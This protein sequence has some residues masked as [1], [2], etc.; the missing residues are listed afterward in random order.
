MYTRTRRRT[1][2]PIDKC[3]RW[4]VRFQATEAPR[5]SSQRSA[6]NRFPPTAMPRHRVS[7]HRTCC[8]TCCRTQSSSFSCGTPSTGARL[9]SSS[10]HLHIFKITLF[11]FQNV[12]RLPALSEARSERRR[13]SSAMCSSSEVRETVSRTVFLERLRLQPWEK[14]ILWETTGGTVSSLLSVPITKLCTAFLYMYKFLCSVR[15]FLIFYALLRGV[16]GFS[17]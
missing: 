11:R 1:H 14:H 13:L 4:N 2:A 12:F 6:G 9:T 5:P 15:I 10:V 8:A 16:G 17:R 3:L 7:G